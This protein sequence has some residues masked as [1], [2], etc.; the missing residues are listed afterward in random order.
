MKQGKMRGLLPAV[1][2][3][4]GDRRS[5]D[6]ELLNQRF[7]QG[8]A[9]VDCRPFRPA[10]EPVGNRDILA[11]IFSH[12]GK[13]CGDVGKKILSFGVKACDFAC[14]RK[15]KVVLKKIF[16]V[17]FKSLFCI[18]KNFLNGIP[19]RETA[20]KVRKLTPITA[21]LIMAKCRISNVHICSLRAFTRVAAI[22]DRLALRLP[23]LNLFP[24]H[25]RVP[26]GLW[27]GNLLF[28]GGGDCLLFVPVANR[29]FE[30]VLKA[31]CLSCFKI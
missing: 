30:E 28:Q 29:S 23:F 24:C 3:G 21:V 11:H 17:T 13:V 27:A 25:R 10:A 8:L 7:L 16:R 22:L 6:A 19:L 18:V 12:V 31:L 26:A 9:E 2:L 4:Y 20:L 15:V 14:R 5:G 1:R